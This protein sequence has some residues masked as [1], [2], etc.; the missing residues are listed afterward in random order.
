MR[1][2]AGRAAL[3]ERLSGAGFVSAPAEADELLAAARDGVA[4]L[5]ALVARRL[6]GEP[7]PWVTGS[8]RFCGLRLEIR[9]GIFVPRPQTEV[10]ARRAVELLPA[11]GAAVDLCT[12]CGAIAAVLMHERPGATVLAT[13]LDPSAVACARGNGVDARL[14]D[15]VEPLPV[16]LR[17]AIDAIT[18]V[19]PYVPTEELHLLPRDVLAFEPRSALDGGPRGL[20]LALRV[21]EAASSWLRSGGSVLL[22][23]GGDQAATVRDAMRANGFDDVVVHRDEDGR[24]RA[25]QARRR[26]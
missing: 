9:P 21:V 19:T 24:D 16:R 25:I 4:P 3:I 22:E 26:S 10:L 17:G 15:L 5:E 11:D 6:G 20:G 7:L 8:L 23:I 12:G 2:D 18:A 1:M 14:G 13:D